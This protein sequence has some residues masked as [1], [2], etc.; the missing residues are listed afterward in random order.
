MRDCPGHAQTVRSRTVGTRDMLELFVETVQLQP[1]KQAE[2]DRIEIHDRRCGTDP[3]RDQQPTQ[4]ARVE[5]RRIGDR[6]ASLHT[7]EK[8]TSDLM[9][10]WRIVESGTWNIMD[11]LRGRG[12]V[13]LCPCRVRPDQRRPAPGLSAFIDP[14][15]TDLDRPRHMAET[16]S[17]EIN[18]KKVLRGYL[19]AADPSGCGRIAGIFENFH[20]RITQRGKLGIVP[21]IVPLILFGDIVAGR[22]HRIRQVVTEGFRRLRK[23]AQVR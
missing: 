23:Q 18:E 14:G 5:P 8:I 2:G 13:I 3:G 21:V 7:A 4:P 17:F 22:M 11:P 12:P 10:R 1:F 6:S 16:R 9:R 15:H 19:H 20:D